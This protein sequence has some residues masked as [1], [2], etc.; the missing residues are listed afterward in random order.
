MPT[1]AQRPAADKDK[2]WAVLALRHAQGIGA[3]SAKRLAE[4]FGGP[5]QAA[6]AALSRPEAWAECGI[7]TRTAARNF[8]AGAWREA[9]RGEWLQ[10]R[11]RPFPFVMWGEA[12]Y[13]PLLAEIPDAPLLLYYRGDASLL[14]G[15]AVAVVG[16]RRC[17]TEGIAVSAW[18][19]RNLA[20][21]GVTVISGM[22]RGID[23]AA[24]LAAL[25]GPGG[26]I[27]V[28]GTGVDIA[29]PACNEDLYRLLAGKGLILSEYA[30]G[31]RP[32]AK[33]FPVRN[34]I[35]SGLARG[36]LV[37]EAAGRSGSLIT[38]RLALEQ[39]RDVFAVPGHTMASLS[40]GCRE[41]IRRGARAVFSADDIL[42]DLAPLLALEAQKALEKRL[43][44]ERR[45]KAEARAQ[46]DD[47]NWPDKVLAQ[48]APDG[49]PWIAAAEKKMNPQTPNRAKTKPVPKK[50]GKNRAGTG[51]ARQAALPGAAPAG[52]SPQLKK[53]DAQRQPRQQPP[54]PQAASPANLSGS[55][56][57][58]DAEQA[59]V[60][61]AL[62]SGPLHIDDLARALDLD[63]AR[64]SG[65][66]IM[67]EMRGLVRRS[68]GMIYA[69]A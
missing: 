53:A 25:Q 49:L 30:P 19:A 47:R 5:L 31:A 40:E 16:A 33:H 51:K 22:A 8:A 45:A 17:T 65:L 24:H 43:A 7:A 12:A 64:L 15:P 14:C 23:R 42:E 2:L 67:L 56:P 61:E 21:A 60:M 48:A 69:R 11:K 1:F 6:E 34:R 66:L 52:Q 39:N 37:V 57:A 32:A 29:Y 36:V 46:G 20:A 58:P 10:L 59:P 62:L 35:I 44:E 38:A 18:F 63:V 55:V 13:P 54:E 26:S 41:L 28:L 68:P 4:H 27:A 3:R 50:T 9:A